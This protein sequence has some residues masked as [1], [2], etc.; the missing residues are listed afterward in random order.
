MQN[1]EQ[2][3]MLI[4]SQNPCKSSKQRARIQ[5]NMWAKV[6]TRVQVRVLGGL[7]QGFSQKSGKGFLQGLGRVQA[8]H[9]VG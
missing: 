5:T 2:L 1:S 9:W 3:Q 4:R 6:Q 8:R 7:Q